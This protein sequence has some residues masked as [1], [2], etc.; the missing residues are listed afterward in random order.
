MF[1]RPEESRRDGSAN[2][3][4]AVVPALVSARAMERPDAPAVACGGEILTYAELERDAA[5][6]AARLRRAGGGPHVIAG[7][8]AD[9]SAALAAGALGI[10]KA[11]AAYLPLDPSYPMERL[12]YMLE[13]AHAPVLLTTEHAAGRVPKGAWRVIG[14]EAA[15]AEPHDAAGPPVRAPRP[16]DLAYAIYTSGSTGRPKGVPITHA[17]LLNLVNWH[18]AAFGITEK[19]RASHLGSLGFDAAIWELWPYLACGASVHMTPDD[20]RVDPERLR[21]WL[22]EERI[23]VAFAPT[24]LAERLIALP[25]PAGTALRFLLTGADTLHR[26]P[27]QGLPFTLVNNYG[28][29]ECTVVATSGTVPPTADHPGIPPIGRPIANTCVYLLDENLSPVADGEAGEICIAG[30]G[31]SPGYLNRDDLT[32]QSFAADPFDPRGGRLYRTGD[33]GRLLPDGQIS[34]LGRKDDQIKMR[35]FRIEPAEITA[36]LNTHPAVRE[37]AVVA[38]G[39]TDSG[40]L[41]AAYIVFES[42]QNAAAEELQEW[43][44]SR[45]PD[46][47]VPRVFVR[48]ESLP[49][50]ASGKLDRRALPEPAEENGMRDGAADAPRSEIELKLAAIV[51]GLLKI[52]SVGVEEN[53]FMLGGNSLL[54]AQLMAAVRQEFGVQ[55]ALRALF[56]AP[57]VAALAREVERLAAARGA[58]G[59]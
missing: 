5:R 31:V 45:L 6:L 24:P 46:Y 9:R 15:L 30:A 49:L 21:D 36:A 8:C 38:R 40:R 19:D 52:G 44:R 28:P 41:L 32:A 34:F 33:L 16:G 7:L 47:M 29:T 25:W 26:R 27:P 50:T 37:S 18:V 53:F 1:A 39:E 51:A 17:S 56:G 3:R 22:V 55:V 54:G 48:L 4:R 14:L 35:G 23:T 11:G 13:D 59:Q 12:S 10:M 42:G 43:L 57:T 2:P 20:V 58:A